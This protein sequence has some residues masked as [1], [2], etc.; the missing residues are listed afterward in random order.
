[1]LNGGGRAA[2]LSKFGLDLSRR[3][4]PKSPTVALTVIVGLMIA[5][6]IVRWFVDGAGQAAALLYVVPIALAALRFGRRGGLV[7]AGFGIGVFVLLGIVHAR[8]DVDLTGWV[9][10][11][12]AMALMGG[13]VGYLS[14]SAGRQEAA[15]RV[16]A[17]H[18][19]ELRGAHYAAVEAGDSI[20]QQIAAARW[21]LE[22]GK[23]QDAL[24]ALNATLAEGITRM[25][26]ALPRLSPNQP[27]LVDGQR[28]GPDDSRVTD[29]EEKPEGGLRSRPHKSIPGDSDT[30]RQ[31]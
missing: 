26:G 10:P 22:A 23:S 12:A 25:S 14:E 28:D 2:K 4:A 19:E 1:M 17:Q 16:Q 27:S 7:S 30:G 3:Y 6:T 21:M 8:G 31:D 13:L 11:A 18:L 24:E 29:P 20:V 9:G 5:V 15:H